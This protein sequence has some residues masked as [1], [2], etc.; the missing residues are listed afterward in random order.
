MAVLEGGELLRLRRR[1]G[2]VARD[3][4]LREAAHGLDAERQRDH[5]EQQPVL[6]LGLVAGEH[7]R[8]HRGAERHDL[9][10][11][12]VVERIAPEE[13]AHR[14]L[15]LRHA[16]CA[17]DHDHALD[18]LHRE[19]RVAQRLAHRPQRFADQGLADAAKGFGIDRKIDH[20][21]RG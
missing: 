8:L 4:L 6:A 20:I 1:D 14:A 19:P 11:V 10:R 7:V 16:R 5:V 15:D 9:V 3:D 17:A 21:A 2:G 18:L 13:L 12:E